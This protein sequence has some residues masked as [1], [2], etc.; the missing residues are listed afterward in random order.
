M[1]GCSS[2]K[3]GARTC[4][5]CDF[6]VNPMSSG[7]QSVVAWPTTEEEEEAL[8]GQQAPG[9]R[10]PVDL[11]WLRKKLWSFRQS[12]FRRWTSTHGGYP[13]KRLALGKAFHS[14]PLFCR[15]KTEQEP[16]CGGGVPSMPFSS[17]WAAPRFLP[18]P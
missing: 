13:S 14:T 16:D 10:A 9:S 5:A 2:P 18:W 12:C 8:Q 15:R 6:Y 4:S 11:H 17:K 1:Y 3:E 7:I